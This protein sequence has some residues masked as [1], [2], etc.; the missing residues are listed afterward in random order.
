MCN[1][2][3]TVRPTIGGV[4]PLPGHSRDRRT[5]AKA[6]I[7]GGAGTAYLLGLAERF[8]AHRAMVQPG[9]PAKSAV[10]IEPTT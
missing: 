3:R 1:P 9:Y 7:P 8:G 4:L 10:R 2:A 6:P 5:S